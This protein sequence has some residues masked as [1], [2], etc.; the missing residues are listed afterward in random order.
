MGFID[1]IKDTVSDHADKADGVI[2]KVADLVDNKTGGKHHEKIDGAATKAKDLVDKID[3][4][5]KNTK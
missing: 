4:E 1:K 2:D 3:D 5:N